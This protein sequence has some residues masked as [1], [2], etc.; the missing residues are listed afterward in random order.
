MTPRVELEAVSVRYD[1]LLAVDGIDLEVQ[2]GEVVAVVGPSGCGKSTLLRAVA[3]LVPLSAGRVCLDG[4]DQEGI[5]VHRRGV[6]LMFQDQA[7]FPHRDV[8]GNVG[9]GLRMQGRAASEIARAVTELLDL[10]GLPGAQRRSV[11]ELS[12]GEQQ[13]V[14]LARSLAPSPRLLL[15]DEPLGALDRTLRERLV[16]DLRGLFGDLGLTVVAVTHDQEDAFA[17]ADRVAAMDGGRLLQIETPAALWDRPAS[18]RVAELLGQP[19][20]IEAEVRGGTAATPWGAL[21]VGGPDGPATLLVRPAAVRL[22]PRGPLAGTVRTARF[23]GQHTT[24]HVE[25]TAGPPLQADV[26]SSSAPAPGSAVRLRI[27]PST[28]ARLG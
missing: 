13:R 22:D 17:L 14:A 2:P 21:T 1:E 25:L 19:N 9:F 26:P 16:A 7:L 12:G 10:V 3:G 6:G 5:A 15:L 4:V 28:A 23:R 27:E 8:A 20:V 18:A 24:L 11:A